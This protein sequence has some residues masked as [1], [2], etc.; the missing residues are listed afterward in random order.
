MSVGEGAGTLLPTVK[1]NLDAF[2]L[3]SDIEG[4]KAP[5]ILHVGSV[6]ELQ[7]IISPHHIKKEPE[8]GEQQCWETQW[9]EFLG[10]LQAPHSVWGNTQMS[11]EPTPWEDAKAFLDSFEQV[12]LACRW[13][14]E[15]WVTL[16][17]P[18][19]SG[20]AKQAF[21]SLRVRD[22]K[23]YGKVKATILQAA[24]IAREKQRQRFR[25]L[26]YQE[27]DGPR[28][29]YGQLQQ[30]CH[31][32]LK[33]ER[34]SKEEILE[35]LILEQFLTVLPQEMQ[36]WVR[37]H[38]P[39]TCIQAVALA[40]DFLLKQKEAIKPEQQVPEGAQEVVSCVPPPDN[41]DFDIEVK[42]E[43]EGEDRLLGGL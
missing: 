14:Q 39:E 1:E 33:A 27:A 21:S 35:L 34:H 24:A 31:Q 23:D 8:D 20:E 3:C 41:W 5:R 19:F 22:T 4:T 37:E 11:E 38:G 6:G 16:L 40:E 43:W 29:V 12:A 25:Q 30:L 36:S 15:K 32:W 28:A 7:N 17:L 10:S 42:Q 26:C 2:K 9:Q 13:P 18:A